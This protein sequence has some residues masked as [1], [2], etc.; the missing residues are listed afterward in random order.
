M[1]IGRIS[2]SVININYHKEKQEPILKVPVNGYNARKSYRVIKDTVELSSV[3]KEPGVLY[4]VV[5]GSL[6]M[7]GDYL[8][9]KEVE[10][11]ERISAEI[12]ERALEI[13]ANRKDELKEQKDTVLG[14]IDSILTNEYYDAED[15]VKAR[16]TPP[17]S[18]DASIA[19]TLYRNSRAIHKVRQIRRV[20]S[21]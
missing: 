9:R 17:V 4:K 12:K 11:Q 13:M 2:N 15:V 20:L 18:E 1:R 14:K 10:R 7:L 5:K 6:E 16:Y 21:A 3:R 19:L 8:E